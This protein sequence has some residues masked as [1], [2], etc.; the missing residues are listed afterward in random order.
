MDIWKIR[1]RDLRGDGGIAD[2]GRERHPT[3][4]DIAEDLCVRLR[5]TS[6][7]A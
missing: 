6:V 4:W 3:S 5:G 7:A 1:H 2:V